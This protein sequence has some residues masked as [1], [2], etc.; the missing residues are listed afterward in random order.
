MENN[1]KDVFDSLK[2]WLLIF[3]AIFALAVTMKLLMPAPANEPEDFT[4]TGMPAEQGQVVGLFMRESFST[5]VNTVKTSVVSISSLHIADPAGTNFPGRSYQEIGSGVVI[6]PDGFIITNYHVVVDA[7][8]IKVTRFDNDHNHFYDAQIVGLY[9]EIDLAILKVD[10]IS[11]FPYAVFGD[12]DRMNV[13]DW[14]LAIGSPFGLD[15]SVTTG[16]I[17]A[18][19]QSL[20]INGAEY[21]DLLQTDASINPGNSGGPLVNI[22]GDVIGINTAISDSP[23]ITNDIGFAIPSNNVTQ[24][25]DSAG[26]AY[27]SR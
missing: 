13:G 26:V 25:L 6:N 19:R 17:S 10:S 8:E 5:L 18:K 3:A 14:I 27:K 7:E 1:T 24:L 9:P 4:G 23:E 22:D 20:F 21:K 15:Q 11:P 2:P 16:I 12:S